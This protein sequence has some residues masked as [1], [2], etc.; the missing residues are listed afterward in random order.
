[1]L[2][3]HAFRVRNNLAKVVCAMA[4]PNERAKYSAIVDRPKIRLPNGERIIV[5]T[6]VNVRG[7]GHFAR[8]A[9]VKCWRHPRGSPSCPTCPIGAGT[10]TGCASVSGVSMRFTNGL[11]SGQA[12]SINARVCI[13]YPRVAQ[14]CKDAG[15]EFHGPQFRTRPIHNEKDQPAMIKRTV[16]DDQGFYGQASLRMDGAWPH[17]NVRYTRLSQGIRDQVH[18]RLGL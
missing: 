8:D 16:G 7:L 5:W 9:R 2:E 14:A 10:N 11:G 13:D 17:G 15:W 18:L 6:I 3:A 12:F 4:L 1:V